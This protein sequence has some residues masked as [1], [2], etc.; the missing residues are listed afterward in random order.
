[1]QPVQI[2]PLILSVPWSER[3]RK[4][5]Q[6]ER[7]QGDTKLRERLRDSRTNVAKLLSFE[8]DMVESDKAAAQLFIQNSSAARNFLDKKISLR[9]GGTKD[10]I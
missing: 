10:A 1:M 6:L 9:L 7:A 4:I 5:R 2:S 3:A 8:Y